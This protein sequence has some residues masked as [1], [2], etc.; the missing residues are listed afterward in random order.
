MRVLDSE[1]EKPYAYLMESV[2]IEYYTER[3]CNLTQVGEKLDDKN[4]GI[5]MRQSERIYSRANNFSLIAQPTVCYRLQVFH[6][7]E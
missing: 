1:R 2:S 5:G 3:N 4:Y 7:T 6:S